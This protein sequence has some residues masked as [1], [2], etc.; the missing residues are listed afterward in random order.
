[1]YILLKIVYLCYGDD[2]LCQY[3]D[4][5]M[6]IPFLYVLSLLALCEIY[7][8]TFVKIS[9]VVVATFISA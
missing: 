9:I 4:F 5:Y 7:F 6:K 3:I 1:M 2:L 8:T